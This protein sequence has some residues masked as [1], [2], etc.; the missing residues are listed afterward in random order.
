MAKQVRD[1]KA[2]RASTKDKVTALAPKPKRR[3]VVYKDIV[4]SDG[5][6]KITV[7]VAK[8]I[9]GWRIVVDDDEIH[10]LKD[11]EGNRIALDNNVMN[12]PYRPTLCK[13]WMSEILR[14]KWRLNGETIIIDRTGQLQS[15]QHTLVALVM[16][17]QLRKLEPD[18]WKSWKGSCFIEKLIVQGIS[19]AND[20]VDT[21]D[22]GQRRSLGDVIARN[23]TFITYGT[24]VQKRLSNDL[25]IATRLVWE[26]QGGKERAFA[27]DF[28]HSEALDFI[29]DHP[30][31]LES[32]KLIHEEDGERQVSKKI[33]RGFA[34]GLH[35]LMCVA[36]TDMDEYVDK[37]PAS[38]NFEL[39]DKAGDFWTLFASG[40]QLKKTDPINV[41]VSNMMMINTAGFVGRQKILGTVI[42]AFNLWVDGKTAK[43]YDV[44][45]VATRID[46]DEVEHLMESP[47]IGGIDVELDG[48]GGNTVDGE[49]VADNSMRGKRKGKTWKAGDTCWVQESGD[50]HWF[51]TIADE[52][53]VD[54]DFGETMC[55]VIAIED[56]EPY[57]AD[58]AKLF[59]SFPANT[60]D[61]ERVE[62]EADE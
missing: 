25:A 50:D 32:V 3:K 7:D 39:E 53:F 34:A 30:K 60:D 33:A 49:Y 20:V 5:D 46:E 61:E 52:E 38:L 45:K 57:E 28:P 36:T 16:A 55:M 37:G 51:G 42:K 2:Q 54:T 19:D 11:L 26:R 1:R 4:I 14:K 31:L 21:I 27:K 10:I 35:Y 6:H 56:D 62:Y 59:V 48:S 29:A 22:L 18:T 8:D 9:L 17:E 47:R 23:Q 24:R 41:L 44:I 40:D 43:D 12:R 58:V 13:R 15:G